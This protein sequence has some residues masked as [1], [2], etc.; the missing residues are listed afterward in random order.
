MY[1]GGI[2]GGCNN[3]LNCYVTNCEIT[4]TATS[5]YNYPYVGGI[6]AYSEGSIENSYVKDSTFTANANYYSKGA[7]SYYSTSCA[8]SDGIAAYIKGDG[9]I[10]YC[11]G[12]S[13]KFYANSTGDIYVGGLAGYIDKTSVSQ[14]YTKS[15]YICMDKYATG[16]KDSVLRR[17]G[18][19]IGSSKN[20]FVTSCFAYNDNVLVEYCSGFKNATD[21]KVAGLIAGFNIVSV[22][23]CAT[24]N[25][26]LSSTTI[27]EFIPAELD[28]LNKCYVSSTQFGNVNNLEV[29]SEHFW[30]SQNSIKSSL[31]LIGVY[32]KFTTNN[33]PYLDFS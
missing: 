25:N 13:N 11:Y 9:N 12:D 2:A 1:A 32:W 33:L 22:M 20:N 6:V 28:E 17:A 31:N 7:T 5:V 3:I 18:G 19:L 26:N 15:T 16:N 30:N 23:N 27:D 8:Y 21:S 10:K 14:S 24:Y 29:L 4:A